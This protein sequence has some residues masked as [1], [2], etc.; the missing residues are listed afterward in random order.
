MRHERPQ[1]DFKTY[2][3]IILN[4]LY[5]KNTIAKIMF[6]NYIPNSYNIS[7]VD[8]VEH[9]TTTDVTPSMG[10]SYVLLSR[11]KWSKNVLEER[12]TPDQVVFGSMDSNF[13]SILG[14]AIHLEHRLDGGMRIDVENQSLFGVSKKAFSAYFIEITGRKASL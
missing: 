9:F 6:F 8:D 10:F 5:S 4:Y 2:I 3:E 11:M 13:C 1:L 12:D 7:R 14:L